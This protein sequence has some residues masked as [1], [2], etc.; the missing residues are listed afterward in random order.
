MSSVPAD[1]IGRRRRRV[2]FETTIVIEYDGKTVKYDQTYNISM[3]GV[4]IKTGKTLPVGT[5]GAF[6]MHLSMGMRTDSIA[7]QCEVIRS[8]CLDDG[9]SEEDPG[10]GIGLKFTSLEPESSRKLFQVI[11][12]NQPA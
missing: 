10:P 4:F 9:L 8:V 11:R 2:P 12:Y 1:D 6:I 3:N 7:G 5:R